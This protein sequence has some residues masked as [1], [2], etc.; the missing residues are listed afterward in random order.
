M[1]RTIIK[2]RNLVASRASS[3][4]ETIES[5]PKIEANVNHWLTDGPIILGVPTVAGDGDQGGVG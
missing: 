1:T 2:S 5:K 4:V 3:A